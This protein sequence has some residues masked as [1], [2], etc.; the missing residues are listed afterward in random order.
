LQLTS[1]RGAGSFEEFLSVGT[2]HRG[3]YLLR[4]LL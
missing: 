3:K 1:A 4:Y 2:A